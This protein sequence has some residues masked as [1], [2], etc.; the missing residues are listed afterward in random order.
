MMKVFF[1]GGRGRVRSLGYPVVSRYFGV[2]L[3]LQGAQDSRLRNILSIVGYSG[4][5]HPEIPDSVSHPT[6]TTAIQAV[7]V[8]NEDT[9]GYP[10]VSGYFGQR[11]PRRVAPDLEMTSKHNFVKNTDASDI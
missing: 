9:L 11:K 7:R 3:A 4:Y 1:E 2:D 6:L 5:R 10:E 8:R